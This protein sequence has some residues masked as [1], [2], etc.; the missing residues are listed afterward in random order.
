M[1]KIKY[2]TIDYSINPKV[3]GK[4]SSPEDHQIN[5]FIDPEN[6]SVERLDLYQEIGIEHVNES[7]SMD[8]FKVQNNANLTGLLSSIYF[9]QGLFVSQKFIDLMLNYQV[10][11]HK[12]I[13]CSLTHKNKKQLYY[14][15]SFITT[16]NIINFNKSKFVITDETKLKPKKIEEIQLISE[17]DLDDK[18]NVLY[19][20]HMNF[21]Y[22][23]RPTKLVLKH[24]VDFLKLDI[25]ETLYV[26]QNLKNKL[27][28]EQLTGIEFKETDIEFYIEE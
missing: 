26:S 12:I 4:L 7:L 18:I 9:P 5:D 23:I 19:L 11:N 13:P 24:K 3:I 6:N 27:E 28:E 21:D 8:K 15:I 10:L 25:D 2:Y 14:I 22:K 17:E 20:K 1:K 16:K